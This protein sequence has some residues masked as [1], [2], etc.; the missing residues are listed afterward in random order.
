M[1]K[2]VNKIIKSLIWTA[3]KVDDS[4]LEN[5]P[6]E[7]P[8]ILAGNHINFLEVPLLYMALQPRPIIAM[9]KEELFKAPGLRG[10]MKAW[11]VIPVKRG[12][13]DIGAM[14]K[15]LEA[16][17][18][19]AFFSLA[20]EGTR[21]R[22]GKL[23]KGR[24]GAVVIAEKSNVPI[25]PVVHWVGEKLSYNLKRFK[26]TPITIK[27]GKPFVIDLG[28]E[29]MNQ[30]TRKKLADELMYQIAENLPSEYRGYYEDM[31]KKTTDFIRFL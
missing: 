15:A 27:V 9:A 26:R 11:K 18:E 30:G 14:R 20:P 4:D 2:I 5:L 3:C 24:P 8:Y 28:E 22:D 31:S 17:K 19:G 25:Y 1:I 10:L 6:L 16:L 12:A 7:G 29:K 23:L 13:A 21:S